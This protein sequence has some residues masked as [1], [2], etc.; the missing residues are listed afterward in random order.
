[1]VLRIETG[2]NSLAFSQPG[3]A[4]GRW[5]VV[6]LIA[7]ALARGAPAQEPFASLTSV[8][9][10]AP[11]PAAQ[12]APASVAYAPGEGATVSML[13]GTSRLK[14]FGQF[15]AI[16]VGSTTRTLPQGGPLLLLP[17]SQ[18]GNGTNTF[19][20]QARQTGFGASF[21]GPEVLGFTPGAFFLGFI[22][23]DSLSTDAY[24]FLPFN[25]YGELKNENWRIAGGLMSDVFNPVTPT[26][27]SLLN[28]YASG[29]TGSFSG[30]FRVE[31][32]Y[33]PIDNFQLTTQVALRKAVASVVTD[34]RRL[35]EDNGWPNV[36][37]R[38]AA[39]FGEVREVAGGRKSRPVEV[40]VSGTVGQLRNSVLFVTADT[41]PPAIRSTVDVWGFGA[42]VQ[43][44]L[45]ER[46]GVMGEFFV[47]QSLGEYNGGIG[48][49]FNSNTLRSIRS[50][51]GFG[52]VYYYFSNAI[53]L[54][55]GYG[56][57]SPLA[58][59]LA[60]SQVVRN[61]TY[62]ANLVW[63]VSKAF[64]VSFEMDYRRTAYTAFRDADGVVLLG[65]LLW[66]F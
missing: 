20:I 57:D 63:D 52:E 34:N 55:V 29:N 60:P 56:I 50:V 38:V 4:M 37:A 27:I 12:P 7:S 19:D 13:N 10:D 22:Q 8:V 46:F 26:M 48:Q 41:P 40:G 28:L 45:T 11:A 15:S 33:K 31:H 21:S 14:V 43:A 2:T 53:H 32:Y 59:D 30:A 49:T 24:G 66:R 61:Q 39:G 1:M 5:A 64:Q 3:A 23:N 51:G 65:Q 47:G 58:R 42:D 35:I 25:A 44:P 54:H 62:F 16:G 18:V 9:S 36:E 6:V 17:R